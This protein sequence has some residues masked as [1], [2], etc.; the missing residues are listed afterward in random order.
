MDD[1][2]KKLFEN[3]Y[4]IVNFKN[5]KYLNLIQTAIQSIFCFDPTLMHQKNIDDDQYLKF[6]KQAKDSL[7]EK[8][9]VKN[10]LLDNIHVFSALFGP[11]IDFQYNIHL[12]ISRPN[13]E[14]DFVNW[15]RDTFNGNT[16]WE[17]NFWFPVFPLE[18][19]SGLAIIESSHSAVPKNIRFIE[20]RNDFRKKVTKGS[21]ANELGYIYAPKVDD[22]I[23]NLDTTK[24]KL[25]TPEIGQVVVFFGHAIHR[26]FNDSQKTRISIDT[27]LKSVHSPT[28]TKLGYYRPLSRG[29]VSLYAEKMQLSDQGY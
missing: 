16:Y 14:G 28:N 20:D 12:R 17:V 21:I 6:V 10:L 4:L 11:D 26:A 13:H 5:T 24:I 2:F 19:N 23:A 8:D 15:H 7:V 18:K 29:C 27:R 9:Y 3:G 25:L 1:N 22:T